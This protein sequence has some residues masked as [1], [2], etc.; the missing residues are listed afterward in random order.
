M[1]WSRAA[2]LAESFEVGRDYLLVERGERGQ[3]L[4]ANFFHWGSILVVVMAWIISPR[5]GGL[6]NL[7]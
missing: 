2:C 4:W 6:D 7:V 5:G 3:A 1:L